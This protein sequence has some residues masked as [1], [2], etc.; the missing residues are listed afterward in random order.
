MGDQ[1]RKTAFTLI[2][3]LVV[4]AIIAILAGLLLPALA[5][6]KASA[7]RTQCISQNKQIGLAVLLYGA[8]F[9]DRAVWPNWGVNNKGWLYTPAGG[10]PPLSPNP[11]TVY[12]GGLLW[13]YI[14][15]NYRIYRC[16]LDNTN[17]PNWISRTDKLSTYV[18]NGA[19]L[20]YHGT[21][22]VGYPTHKITD[23]NPSAFML[24][25]PDA[26]TPA[27]AQ[28]SY[29]DGASQPDQADGPSTRH[30]SGCVVTG[31][32]GHA[33]VLKFDVFAAAM[34]RKGTSPTLLWADP[35]SVD[36]AGYNGTATGN[37]CSLPK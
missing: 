34:E 24:W 10:P 35:D 31:Y 25:E 13:D 19:V 11:E 32:D 33:Q 29:N 21:P 14:S 1:Q 26:S 22:L 36:G 27:A 15:H 18:M 16:P 3:L 30:Q 7:Q 20:A 37:G 8:D 23:M 9:E 28:I 2:E 12:S 4:I 6:A 17:S 5:K